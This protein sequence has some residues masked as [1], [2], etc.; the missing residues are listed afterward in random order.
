M[1][2]PRNNITKFPTEIRMRIC[3]LLEDG[4]T[5]DEIREDETVK[6]AC[7]DRKLAIHNST[8]GA[9]RSSTEFDEYKKFRRNW[10]E[11][12]VR[13]RMSAMLVNSESGSDNIA[14]IATFEL[15][16]IVL[17][18]L[19]SGQALDD[20]EIKAMSSALASYER[21]R[22]SADKDKSEKKLTDTEANYQTEITGL[23][24]TI[25]KLTEKLGSIP[26]DSSKTIEAMDSFV[27][28]E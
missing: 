13:N 25:A 1:A 5:Y 26:L 20:K 18:K 21:N 11:K 15:L 2:R 7:A 14:K 27:K 9:Y 28:G 19:Q 4:R 17:D 23:K 3:E 24:E 16:N 6:A 8:L 10:S 22:I 12:I